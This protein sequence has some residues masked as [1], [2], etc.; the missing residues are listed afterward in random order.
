MEATDQKGAADL[1]SST[2][3]GLS[4]TPAL[5]SPQRK[6]IAGTHESAILTWYLFLPE[7]GCH[8][9]PIAGRPCHA[10]AVKDDW[11]S[12]GQARDTSYTE[13]EASILCPSG[14][15]LMTHQ[16]LELHPQGVVLWG[17]HRNKSF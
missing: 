5:I 14:L 12:S 1:G 4:A 8:C 3:S 13:V 9:L 11:A 6:V 16:V 17:A 10:R 15:Y 7:K 2:G